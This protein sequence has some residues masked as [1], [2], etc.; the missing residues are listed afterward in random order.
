MF[1]SGF[2]KRSSAEETA[3]SSDDHGKVST[4]LITCGNVDEIGRRDGFVPAA[5]LPS[6]IVSSRSSSNDLMSASL[7]IRVNQLQY[8]IILPTACS[9]TSCFIRLV[10]CR[11]SSS[12]IATTT[13]RA[14]YDK[15]TGNRSHDQSPTVTAV[16]PST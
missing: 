5:T 10:F 9:V 13:R 14:R 1:G 2:R 15:S 6:S 8:N 16:V 7:F 12:S 4:C 3:S 11:T